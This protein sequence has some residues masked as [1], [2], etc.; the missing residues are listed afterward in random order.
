MILARPL[1]LVMI[2]RGEWAEP[3]W[4]QEKDAVAWADEQEKQG[5]PGHFRVCAYPTHERFPSPIHKGW[6]ERMVKGRF[7]V[8]KAELKD[9]WWYMGRCRNANYAQ[10]DATRKFPEAKYEP[11]KSQTGCF[12]HWRE[13]FDRT[14]VETINHPED[15]DEFDLFWPV[16]RVYPD[17]GWDDIR[18]KGF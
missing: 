7:I 15:D 12:V 11:H 13:K 4:E 5:K 16:E 9:G 18:G 14:F 2:E 6:Y 10:W 1:Y 3:V 17:A 8:P